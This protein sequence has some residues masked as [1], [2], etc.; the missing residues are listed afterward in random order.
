ML[1]MALHS[2]WQVSTECSDLLFPD[3]IKGLPINVTAFLQKSLEVQKLG[4]C[5]PPRFYVLKVEASEH[6]WL[7]LLTDAG[8][9]ATAPVAA[10]KDSEG[11]AG[12]SRDTILVGYPKWS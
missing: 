1:S 10:S 6:C 7:E 4:M 11:G 9:P 12:K 3:G 2:S 5:S 8:V